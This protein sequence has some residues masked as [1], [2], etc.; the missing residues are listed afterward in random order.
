MREEI[1]GVCGGWGWRM[2]CLSDCQVEG[3]L[4]HTSRDESF[5][6]CKQILNWE[7]Y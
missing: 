7:I 1:G 2:H 4:A 6:F 5:K 3:T